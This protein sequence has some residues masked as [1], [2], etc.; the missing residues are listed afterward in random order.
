MRWMGWVGSLTDLENFALEGLVIGWL[1]VNT[2]GVEGNFGLGWRWREEDD[3][4][5]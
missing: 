2:G 4:E 3:G 1:A 5:S